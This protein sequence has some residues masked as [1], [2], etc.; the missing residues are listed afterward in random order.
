MTEE[1]HFILLVTNGIYIIIHNVISYNYTNL[2]TLYDYMIKFY[3]IKRNIII[4]H[5]YIPIISSNS[6]IKIMHVI[7][8]GN[9][10]F[11]WKIIHE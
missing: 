9:D 11:N 10:F 7:E 4:S 8:Y 1:I 5:D 3:L 2:N 6:S